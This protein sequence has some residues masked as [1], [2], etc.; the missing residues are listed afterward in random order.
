MAKTADQKPL[1]LRPLADR[2]LVAAL[3]RIAHVI[4]PYP[5][6]AKPEELNAAIA[7]LRAKGLIHGT[8]K[9]PNLSAK[10]VEAARKFASKD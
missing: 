8:A 1:D 2:I 9:S 7:T 5:A 10:G 3:A 6:D 4:K